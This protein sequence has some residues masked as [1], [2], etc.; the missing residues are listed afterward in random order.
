MYAGIIFYNDTP[1]MLRE[2][3][4]ALKACQITTIAIDGAF[5]EFL[6]EDI[7][8][9]L[10][11]YSTD[12]CIEVAREL[13]DYYMPALPWCWYDQP[14]KRSAYLHLVP[15]GSHLLVIDADEI[16]QPGI[17]SHDNL[18]DT[19]RV[20]L[21]PES[22]SSVR[23][24]KTKPYLKYLY[25]HCSMY[26]MTRHILNNFESG[27]IVQAHSLSNAEKPILK[28]TNGKPVTLLHKKADRSPERKQVKEKFYLNRKETYYKNLQETNTK[29]AGVLTHKKII[30]AIATM[31]SRRDFLIKTVESIIDQVD[32]LNICFNDYRKFKHTPYQIQQYKNV[33]LYMPS[34]DYGSIGRFLWNIE[35]D[36]Y[37]CMFDDDL[38]YPPDYIK[39]LIN[40]SIR[41]NDKA[42]ITLHGKTFK[43]PKVN[44]WRLDVEGIHACLNTVQND[45]FVHV[46]GTGAM[47]FDSSLVTITEK[48]FKNLL[49]DDIE[50]SLLMQQQKIPI[51]VLRHTSEYLKYQEV[52]EDTIWNR[53]TRN[54][55]MTNDLN[56]LVQSIEWRNYGK[57]NC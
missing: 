3:L 54:P 17:I 48:D 52:G 34:Q 40:G 26:D 1:E 44:H 8:G 18:T 7:T 13:A 25:R 47:L 9:K 41:Y 36:A 43:N 2:C 21:S 38:I 57:G 51:V 29:V 49:Y 27:S 16:M 39:Y 4:T 56:R 15:D 23:V 14:Q 37:Y 11:P 30:G 35:K 55:E 20:M 24:Y 6:A 31:Y 19:M 32:V 42:V 10:K 5:R 50:F 45:T 12:G 28:Y 53:T 46:G 22:F 33:N